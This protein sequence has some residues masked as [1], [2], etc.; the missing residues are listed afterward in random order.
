M[1][2]QVT[3]YIKK[4][5]P[6]QKKICN[7]LR[8]LILKTFPKINEQKKWGVPCYD[9]GR[10]YFVGLKDSV[11]L[12]FAVK[13]LGKKDVKNFKGKGKYMRH[14]KFKSIKEINEKEIIKLLKLVKKK[15]KCV[16]CC[17]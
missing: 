2:K 13:G 4:Q 11:N 12:G 16:S 17:R 14:L 9:H 1:N 8:K 6:T 15:A 7:K 3:A 10:F 5:K